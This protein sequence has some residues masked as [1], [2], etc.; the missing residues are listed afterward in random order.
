M[1]PNLCM[2]LCVN[3]SFG[4]WERI[5]YTGT[6]YLSCGSGGGGGWGG[7]RIIT[8]EKNPFFV[9]IAACQPSGLNTLQRVPNPELL[10]T[11]PSSGSSVSATVPRHFFLLFL[12]SFRPTIINDGTLQPWQGAYR[13]KKS[14]VADSTAQLKLL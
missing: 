13:D 6:A 12:A 8:R 11:P 10:W 1:K 2:L 7:T 9:C 3:C 4:P 14:L 5:A